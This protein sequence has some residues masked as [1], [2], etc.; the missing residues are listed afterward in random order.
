MQ[1]LTM[2]ISDS[3]LILK[4]NNLEETQVVSFPITMDEFGFC[5]VQLTKECLD[6]IVDAVNVN[7]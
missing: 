2:E 4:Y 3:K 6:D 1:K 7:Q 5:N